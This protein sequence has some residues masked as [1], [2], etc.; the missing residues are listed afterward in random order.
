MDPSFI[1]GGLDIQDGMSRTKPPE[2]GSVNDPMADL[3]LS[4]NGPSKMN[5]LGWRE[6][7]AS[8]YAR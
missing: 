6:R 4:D 7:A 5:V 1:E 3:K 8:P 2:A